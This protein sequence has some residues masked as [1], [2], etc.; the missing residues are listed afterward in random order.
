MKLLRT[1][2]LALILIAPSA[3]F[4][5]GKLANFPYSKS[6]QAIVVTTKNWNTVQ[7]TAQRFERSNR[8][9]AWKPVGQS[10]SIVVGKNGLAWSDDAAMKAETEPHKREGD[11]RSPAGIFSLTSAFGSSDKASWINLPYTKL[12]EGTEC[13]DDSK[14]AHYNTIIDRAETGSVDWNSSEKMLAVGTPYDLGVFVAH[15][16]SPATP[17]KGSCIFLHIWSGADKGTSGCTAMERPNIESVLRW[18][19]PDQNPVLIQMPADD[20]QR[21]QTLWKFPKIK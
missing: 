11:G 15:N 14:S 21:F 3:V 16:S 13:V 9:A 7:G 12:V 19:K 5:Q 4:S 8:K 17:Q 10:F 1:L 2:W 18:I 6:L 20:Y